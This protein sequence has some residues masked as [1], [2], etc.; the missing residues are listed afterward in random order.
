MAPLPGGT[1]TLNAE[2][3]EGSAGHSC[4]EP[5]CFG[6]RVRPPYIRRNAI[7]GD[8]RAANGLIE[9]RRGERAARSAARP[10]MAV[11]MEARRSGASGF[12]GRLSGCAIVRT[13]CPTP[14]IADE[15]ESPL[16][17]LHALLGGLVVGDLADGFGLARGF[18]GRRWSL[19]P[20]RSFRP[21]ASAVVRGASGASALRCAGIHSKSWL[22]YSTD[23]RFPPCSRSPSDRLPKFLS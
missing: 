14:P 12:R 16:R 3:A 7:A 21:S 2:M 6:R 19:F 11:E 17:F 4:H 22:S 18:H 23:N 9:E 1:A 15:P 20:E 8:R 13:A 10:L 5:R